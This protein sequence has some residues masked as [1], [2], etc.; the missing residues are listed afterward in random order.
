MSKGRFEGRCAVVTGAGS[1]IGQATA[2]LLA[3]DGAHVVAVDVPGVELTFPASAEYSGQNRIAGLNLDITEAAAPER[4]VQEA[5]GRFGRLDILVN[6]AGIAANSLVETMSDELW[7]RV[8]DVNLRA[9]FRL[10]RAAVP[11]LKDSPAGRIVNVASVMAEGTDYGLGAYCAAKAGVG[12]LT[13]TLALE[14]GK[15]GITA[16]YVLPG[17]IRTGMTQST[18]E[19]DEIAAIWAKKA[20]LRRLGAPEDVAR[21]ILLLASDDAAFITGHGLNADGGVMLRV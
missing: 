4:I 19:Q 12:G 2:R 6:N 10:V 11:M 20:A 3:E 13:R 8:V 16:N 21:A 1:G 17:A 5:Q 7:D 15:F 18:F 9:Q 14:L